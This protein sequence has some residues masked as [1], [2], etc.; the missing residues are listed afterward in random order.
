MSINISICVTHSDRHRLIIAIKNHGLSFLVVNVPAAARKTDGFVS[1]SSTE[2]DA[3]NESKD[4]ADAGRDKYREQAT[5][6]V[7]SSQPAELHHRSLRLKVG[8]DG[9][10]MHLL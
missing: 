3:I 10:H 7:Q 6:S 5:E 9:P 4:Q 8:H 1:V 2:R